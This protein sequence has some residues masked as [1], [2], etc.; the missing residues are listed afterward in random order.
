MA[1]P[2][3]PGPV[4]GL[5]HAPVPDHGADREDSLH[6]IDFG[7]GDQGG[8]P[9]ETVPD[10]EEPAQTLRAQMVHGRDEVG[11][12]GRL[13]VEV[14]D[15]AGGVTVAMVIEAHRVEPETGHPAGHPGPVLVVVRRHR[16]SPAVEEDDSD[17]LRLS[18][19]V[20]DDPEQGVG[21]MGEEDRSLLEAG[22]RLRHLRDFSFP[23]SPGR[24]RSASG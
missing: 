20:G 23:P 2:V 14:V 7:G 12:E 16:V 17:P 8:A 15:T 13:V 24:S 4:V 5:V 9:T 3:L 22:R 1:Y 21:A 6:L 19:R 18:H 11:R 10:E